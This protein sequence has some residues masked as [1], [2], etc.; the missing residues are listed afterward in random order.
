MQ[1]LKF[2]G[3]GGAFFP[4][5]GNTSAYFIED[6]TMYLFDCGETVFATLMKD[7]KLLNLIEDND[8]D[9]IEIY[10]THMHSDHVG[11]L[12]SLVYYCHFVLG[13][14]PKLYHKSIIV[15]NDVVKNELNHFL[16]I[17][18]HEKGQYEILDKPSKGIKAVRCCHV[19]G[20]IC[21]HYLITTKSGRKIFYSGDC[22]K[23]LDVTL[24]N[25]EEADEIYLECS[26]R[27]SGVHMTLSII[28]SYMKRFNNKL[29]DR[30]YLMHIDNLEL[31]E[32]AK[33]YNLKV[34]ELDK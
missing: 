23:I 25:L 2:L 13:I 10:I 8:V 20:M 30:V 24:L 18:G 32:K 17:Q 28:N 1:T 5:E 7:N 27:E 22:F 9:N 26:T 33:E 14:K 21:Y 3:R 31:I 12:S 11:S 4:Q 19:E 6:N 29:N 34:V 15:I 16:Q